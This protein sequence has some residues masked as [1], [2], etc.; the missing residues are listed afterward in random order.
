MA[1]NDF[2]ISLSDSGIKKVPWLSEYIKTPIDSLAT[3]MLMSGI[4]N[5]MDRGDNPYYIR[6]Y[7]AYEK[8]F[9][10]L[11]QQTVNKIEKNTTRISSYFNGDALQFIKDAPN[12]VGFISY[13]PFSNAG[14]AHIASFSKLELLFQYEQSNYTIFNE[15]ML[16]EYFKLISEKKYWCICT[17][18]QLPAPFDENIKAISK[19]TNRA[20]SICI[21]ANTGKTCLISP[22]QE[23]AELKI[24]RLMPNDELGD[25][26]ELKLL[27][28]ATFQTLRSEYMNINIRPGYAIMA[29]GVFVD[30]KLCGVYAFATPPN[31]ANWDSYMDTPYIYLLSDFPV[32]PVDYDRL[33]KLVLYAALSKE[34]KLLAE[35]ITR[36]RIKSLVTTA[37]S[38][39][40]EV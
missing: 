22:R 34:S 10:S 40:P 16:L 39:N 20:V 5:Y 18:I 38:N 8:Q 25:K 11:H 14:K 9:A 3:V 28:K 33:A 1:G 36:R 12:D 30:D 27:S 4:A 13:P 24:P 37:Y 19:T 31:H 23:L 35:S 17:N 15:E 6:M 21:Y 7:N 26:I 29:V 2:K 32:E